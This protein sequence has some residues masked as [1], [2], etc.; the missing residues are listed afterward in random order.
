M[1][2][3]GLSGHRSAHA[4]AKSGSKVSIVHQAFGASTYII[5]FNVPIGHADPRDNSEIYY[6]DI[7][8][9]GYFLN[10]KRLVEV[11]A[12]NSINSFYE[13]V[14]L[15]V[16][17]VKKDNFYLQRHLSGNRYPRSVYNPDG[18]GKLALKALEKSCQKLGVQSLSGW[19]V[20]S[21]LIDQGEVVGALLIK[22][23]SQELLIVRANSVVIALG[24]IGGIYSDST[25][26]T[27]VSA[28]SYALAL[29]A[30]ATLIDMEFVQFE[31]TVVVYPEGCKGMEMPTAM[32]GDGAFLKN[33]FGERFMFRH[34]PEYGERQ[35]EKAKMALCIQEEISSG[36]AFSD[37]TVLF[38]TTVLS[39]EKLKSYSSHYKRLISSGVN[40]EIECARVRPARLG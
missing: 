9:G 38:D 18:I 32:L 40:P 13:L 20:L 22:K 1:L 33:V 10:E 23:N 14:D 25:Y 7:L 39:I 17:F 5:G 29:Q 26:P 15:K 27:D 6:E 4:A 8:Q 16:P 11:V 2:G 24:G 12:N 30:G 3:G 19:K 36:R 21:F 35:I 31:P 34:N 28:D 37:G